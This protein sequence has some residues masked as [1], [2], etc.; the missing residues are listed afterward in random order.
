MEKE[1]PLSSRHNFTKCRLF[2]VELLLS[3]TFGLL[4]VFVGKILFSYVLHSP[5][6]NERWCWPVHMGQCEDRQRQRVLFRLVFLSWLLFVFVTSLYLWKKTRHRLESCPC[7]VMVASMVMG[8][9][10]RGEVLNYY[11]VLILLLYCISVVWLIIETFPVSVR[12]H[13]F[14]IWYEII[15]YPGVMCFQ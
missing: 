13:H 8:C 4:S 6:R 1:I 11:V 7:L 12:R 2:G 5:R 15:I 9:V 10:C 14:F 3:E